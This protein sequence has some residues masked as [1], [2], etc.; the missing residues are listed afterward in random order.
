MYLAS[1]QLANLLDESLTRED[2]R[3]PQALDVRTRYPNAESRTAE[4]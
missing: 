1:V 3:R 2:A 4:R